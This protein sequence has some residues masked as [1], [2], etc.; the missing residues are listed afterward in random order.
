MRFG[1]HFAAGTSEGQAPVRSRLVTTLGLSTT[2]A[3]AACSPAP[4]PV[5]VSAEHDGLAV[6]GQVTSTG[7]SI[8]VDVVV[9][10]N[11]EEPIHLVPDQCGRVVDVE[12]ERT[13][14]Q[15]EGTRWEGS[16]QAV[17]EIVLRD[18]RFDDGPD[19]FAPRRVGDSSAATP[20]CRRPDQL[21]VLEPGA[22][23]AERWEL[24]FD[25]SQT[26]KEVGSAAG[27][28]SLEAIEARDSNEMEYS[29]IVYFSDEDAVRE[30][31]AARAELAL[32]KVLDRAPTEPVSGPSRGELFDRLLVDDELRAWIQDQP[33]DAWGH[34]DL[35]PAYPG[36]GPEFERVR[37]ELVAN[38]FEHAAVVTA[39]P[40]GSNPVLDLPGD[41]DRTREF[42]RTAGS[43]PPGVAALPDADYDLTEDLALGDV[44]LP[45]GRVIVGEYLFDADPLGFEVAPGAYPAHATLARYDE[46]DYDS[47]A[48]AT[49]VL[50]DAPTVRWEEAT[51]IAV[52]G[53]T[54][55]ITSVEGRDEL[56]R[57]FDDDQPG[58]MQL[59]E[60]I[61]YSMVAHDSLGTEWELDARS[62]P[63]ARV[64]RDRRRR[65]PGVRRVRRGRESDP[66][67]RRFPVAPPRLAGRLRYDVRRNA[68][69]GT[70]FVLPASPENRATAGSPA[71]ITSEVPPVSGRRTGPGPPV[72]AARER[73][74]QV[75]AAKAGG[76]AGAPESLSSCRGR[77]VS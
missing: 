76:T 45:S 28:V 39:A 24:P 31:R 42:P 58:S 3:L 70:R 13:A 7:G 17:K 77:E 20:E 56:G 10:N 59:D 62:E 2:L 65:L 44:L 66:G 60:E 38:T 57:L 32:S 23:I 50:S 61:F 49:L 26:L 64:D 11:R 1:I 75:R 47:V 30:G 41:E 19:F 15:P 8:A 18:Q 12:L 4:E 68:S 72:S 67:R 22:T 37:L 25:M 71:T 29:D 36:Y 73:G 46:D 6:E 53:G 48:F 55:T 9:R 43:L 16:I 14:F 35:R 63:G 69:I 5:P 74:T 33:S 54:A 52:D 21:T 40:D 34:A 51:D 27:V